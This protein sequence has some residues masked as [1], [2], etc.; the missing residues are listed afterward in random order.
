MPQTSRGK[1]RPR[2]ICGGTMPQCYDPRIGGRQC[3]LSTDRRHRDTKL[4][5]P[6]TGQ[7]MQTI[8][9]VTA[10]VARSSDRVTAPSDGWPGSR[11]AGVRNH[12]EVAPASYHG[13]PGTAQTGPPGRMFA[14]LTA[15]VRSGAAAPT[16]LNRD[17]MAHDIECAPGVVPRTAAHPD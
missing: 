4:M 16:A 5:C 11:F 8:K 15:R 12:S 6:D 17:Q 9:V 2:G 7:S 14:H 13:C 10:Q 3:T 1:N